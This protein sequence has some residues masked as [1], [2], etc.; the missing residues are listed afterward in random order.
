MNTERFEKLIKKDGFPKYK[1]FLRGQLRSAIDF[2]AQKKAPGRAASKF[3]G[4]PDLPPGFS[5]PQHDEGPYR[6][7]CQLNFSE[8]PEV[9]V[10]MPKQGLFSLFVKD[11][12]DQD[13]QLPWESDFAKGFYFGTGETLVPT[14]TPEMVRL[15]QCVSL[16]FTSGV[17]LP[18]GG[19]DD[20]IWKAMEQAVDYDA[21]RGELRT[22]RSIGR[23]L[24]FPTHGTVLDDLTPGPEW[25]TL[26]NLKSDDD[27]AFGWMD[28]DR[29]SAFIEHD[30]LA[31]EDF[32]N[33]KTEAA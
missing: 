18:F 16:A 11:Y 4:D 13:E 2:V 26:L 10:A 25:G 29:L 8:L 1:S 17:D 19:Y 15:G 32:S 30:R 14:A 28:G 31:Q 22:E 20:E 27:L 9:D 5:W 7:V 21:L 23:L 33:L 12:P 3:N 6:F 24:G